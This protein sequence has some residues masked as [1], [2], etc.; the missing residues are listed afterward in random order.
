MATET[1]GTGR[2]SDSTLLTFENDKNEIIQYLSRRFVPK[3]TNQASGAVQEVQ[4]GDRPD[5][6]AYRAYGNP[7]SYYHIADYNLSMNPFTLTTTPGR[8]LVVPLITT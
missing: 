4:P 3:E 1:K 8:L 6:V 7:L 2:Y 5:L